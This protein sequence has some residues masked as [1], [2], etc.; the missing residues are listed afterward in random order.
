MSDHDEPGSPSRDG[1]LPES[2]TTP[3]SP[4]LPAGRRGSSSND[5]APTVSIDLSASGG[6]VTPP[7]Q[8]PSLAPAESPPRE[9]VPVFG[10]SEVFEGACIGRYT[11]AE[12][13]GSGTFGEVWRARDGELPRE[14]ALKILKSGM[15]VPEFLSRFEQERQVLSQLR[16]RAIATVYGGGVTPEG[17]PYFAMELVRGAPLT[18]FC[19]RE[20]LGIRERLELFIDVC[21][22][23]QHAHLNNIA[24]R[25]LKPDNVLVEN[26][27]A[28]KPRPVVIDFGLAKLLTGFIGTRAHDTGMFQMV[29]TD[30]YMSPEQ[31]DP[32]AVG[33]DNL[34]DVYSL[35]VMLYE[36][37]TGV[38]PFNFR[39][40]RARRDYGEI[41]RILRD[42][43]PPAPSTQ[44]SSVAGSDAKRASAIAQA[45][46]AD[47]RALEGLLQRELQYIPLK[48]M[49]KE[50]R[51]RYASPR[52]LAEDIR[53]YLDGLPL[54]AAPDSA[55]Y[56][57]QKYVRRNRAKVVAAGA[58]V[59]GLGVGA[60]GVVR[61][62]LTEARTAATRLEGQLAIEKR[63]AAERRAKQLAEQRA[64][65]KSILEP[66][67]EAGVDGA[68]EDGR[69]SALLAAR[70][71]A[72]DAWRRFCERGDPGAGDP[73]GRI[74]L[75][76]DLALLARAAVGTARAASSGRV[77]VAGAGDPSLRAEWLAIADQA[78]SRM[79]AIDPSAEAV[80]EA[81][82][83]RGRMQADEMLRE[84]KAGD[85]LAFAERLLAD[86]ESGILR[87]ADAGVV[88]RVAREAG[89]LRVFIAE[90]MWNSVIPKVQAGAAREEVDA[91]MSRAMTL[92]DAECARR[93][94][95]LS[96]ASEA[97]RATLGT[98]LMVAIE[99]AA[100]MRV[101]PR[102]AP[103]RDA[104]ERD[105]LG[106][107]SIRLADEYERVFRAI[108]EGALTAAEQL[109]YATAVARF[110]DAQLWRME[111][112]KAVGGEG[113]SAVRAAFDRSTAMQLQC[114]LTD[115]SNLRGYTELLK[116]T[117]RYLGAHRGLDEA[118]RTSTLE[119]IDRVVLAPVR[120]TRGTI[121]ATAEVAAARRALEMAVS[122]RLALCVADDGPDAWLRREALATRAFVSAGEVMREL[123]DG[124]LPGG[125][126]I[127]RARQ[128]MAEAEVAA[129]LASQLGLEGATAVRDGLVALYAEERVQP[130]VKRDVD[131]YP[132]VTK[133]R[134]AILSTDRLRRASEP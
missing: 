106:D 38:R 90:R 6:A 118:W 83:A 20:K 129:L 134:D 45:R 13:I 35:G 107:A 28:G 105:R 133:E 108:P 132:Y 104:D 92:L 27:A 18:T 74:E 123:A 56:R 8:S 112:A 81:Q 125:L 31:A 34:T 26:D 41:R 10:G 17:R 69:R 65:L 72:A 113:W 23:V 73:R 94:D 1:G 67:L 48:A 30:E 71:R 96:N 5:S 88:A 78:I 60:A 58:I 25:D 82:L 4:P 39:E 68:R 97:S 46:R 54:R 40:Q 131:P 52:E 62:E 66:L 43:E 119:R 3:S 55:L 70:I 93:R 121:R 116:F 111:G 114:V 7:V 115:P 57:A 75:L 86:A 110:A 33:I 44:I 19:D 37:L 21:E 117:Q 124:T 126:P 50:R 122:S 12:L 85:A 61:S 130:L 80:A 51:E 22:G 53:R 59:V 2:R 89:L 98:D 95:A 84:G 15:D 14:V 36:L 9:R 77:N 100:A 29:G 47:L 91:A 103:V 101:D 64:A 63:D 79:A 109:E 16:H 128:L 127:D 102:V 99:K 24:H 49:R 11:L 120:E 87:S 32:Y 76:E 42:V